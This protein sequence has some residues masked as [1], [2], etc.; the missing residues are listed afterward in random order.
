MTIRLYSWVLS[1]NPK[2]IGILYLIFAGVAGIDGT[3]FSMRIRF[4]LSSLPAP[5]I[6]VYANQRGYN[7]F[8]TAHAILMIFF[9][10]MPALIGGFSNL[11]VPILIGA[12]DMA[13]PRLNSISLWLLPPSLL[14]I[15]CSA[16]IEVGAGVG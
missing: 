2:E 8:I 6:S 16:L 11:F 7:V 14:L 1:T 9:L 15:L 5:F 13:L 4:E 10:V 12:P 3:C